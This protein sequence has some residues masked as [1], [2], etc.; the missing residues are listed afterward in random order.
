[1]GVFTYLGTSISNLTN[2]WVTTASSNAVSAITPVV[3]AGASLYISIFGYM[4]I[5]G[6]VQNSFQ[7]FLVKCAK[8][9]IVASMAIN[10]GIYQGNIIQMATG[11]QDG[12]PQL[13]GITAPGD[14]VYTLLD[15]A[16]LDGINDGVHKMFMKAD[17][18]DWDDVG[19]TI[20]YYAM[21][22]IMAIALMV[23][24][25][26]SAAYIIISK[27]AL[28]IILGVGPIFLAGYAFPPTQKF[29]DQWVSAVMNYVV[30]AFVA[31]AV[32]SLCVTIFVK[33]AGQV[34][35]DADATMIQIFYNILSILIV[36]VVLGLLALQSPSIAS[37]LAGG[38]GLSSFN[39]ISMASN[40][41]NSVMR[42]GSKVSN[43]VQRGAANSTRA[44]NYAK[45]PAYRQ[46]V[47]SR[48]ARSLG[49]YNR[50]KSSGD[51]KVK[52]NDSGSNA[53]KAQPS[54]NQTANAYRPAAA[55]NT[56]AMNYRPPS[57][58]AASGEKKAA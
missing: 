48:A 32:A 43:A 19:G 58:S 47:N 44:V 26:I 30:T 46:A 8:L 23:I 38:L 16:Y 31:A 3:I 45:N 33:Y 35:F 14:T 1:M 36:S 55:K 13:F 57:R 6:R 11:L 29:G 17:E 52:R 20:A 12:L 22:F 2:A 4:I 51:G 53:N 18:A 50:G 37:S 24:T 27:V 49:F 42:G 21:G 34:T 41:V 56:A 5:A 25:I 15:K 39:P 7:E 10:L 28:C 9:I 54:Q 40:A